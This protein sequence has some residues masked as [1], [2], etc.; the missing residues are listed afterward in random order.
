VVDGANAFQDA[1]RAERMRRVEEERAERAA[2]LEKDR[3][4]MSKA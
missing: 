4:E 2:Q 1:A 3:K